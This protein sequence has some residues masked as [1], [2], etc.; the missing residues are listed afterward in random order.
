M[1]GDFNLVVKFM[2]ATFSK[3]TELPYI[4]V[5]DSTVKVKFVL[6]KGDSKEKTLCFLTDGSESISISVS[7]ESASFIEFI[8]ANALFPTQLSYIWNPELQVYDCTNPQ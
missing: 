4:A 5:D 1:D 8:K 7:L 3:E 6:H 2:N